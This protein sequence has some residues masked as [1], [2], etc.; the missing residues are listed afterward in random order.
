LILLQNSTTTPL[1]LTLLTNPMY[2]LF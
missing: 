1:G 2:F